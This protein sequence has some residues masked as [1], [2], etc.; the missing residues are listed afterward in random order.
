MAPQNNA[1]YD[2]I[3][4]NAAFDPLAGNV[5]GMQ[6]PL[7]SRPNARDPIQ[8]VP[9]EPAPGAN[10]SGSKDISDDW[11]GE[12]MSAEKSGS[13]NQRHSNLS[14]NQKAQINQ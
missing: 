3:A 14:N 6:N 8:S 13:T 10:N 7:H 1:P 5:P 12:N 2:P 11:I 4:G 9:Y